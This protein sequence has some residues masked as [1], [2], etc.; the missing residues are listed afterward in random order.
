MKI[1][2]IWV[3]KTL[4]GTHRNVIHVNGRTTNKLN[5]AITVTKMETKSSKN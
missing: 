5:E 3:K 2:Q 1:E 4:Y